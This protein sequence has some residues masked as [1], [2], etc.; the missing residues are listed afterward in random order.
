MLESGVY[1]ASPATTPG[2]VDDEELLPSFRT[3]KKQLHQPT[4]V[5]DKILNAQPLALLTI[6]CLQVEIIL[7]KISLLTHFYFRLLYFL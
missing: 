1:C 2:S 5:F 6:S 7:L 3:Q 4:S